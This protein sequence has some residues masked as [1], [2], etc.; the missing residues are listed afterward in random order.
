M[1]AKKGV[2]LIGRS[3]NSASASSHCILPNKKSQI[4][5]SV[6]YNT[7]T[8]RLS[9]VRKILL[10]SLLTSLTESFGVLSTARSSSRLSAAQLLEFEEPQT[11]VKVILVGAMHYN[12]AS[13][14]LAKETIERLGNENRLGSVVV[15][16]CDIR[17]NKTAELYA[18]KPFL[19][20]ILNNEMRTACDAAL[21]FGRPVVLGDQQINVTVTALKASFKQ[22][23][24]DLV[25]PP[26][27]W[28]RFVEEVQE[29]WKETV[30]FGGDG[31]LSA[32]AFFDPRLLL[33][34]PVSLVKYPLSYLVRDPVPTSIGLTLLGALS[35]LDDPTSLESLLADDSISI[36]D[37]LLS[38]GF[39][40]LETAVFARLLL[41]PLLAE[42]NEVLAKRILD[43][44]KI[45]STNKEPK[46]KWSGL[47]WFGLAN[48]EPL[49]DQSTTIYAPGSPIIVSSDKSD[50]VVVAVLGMAHCNGIKRLL[51]ESS[52]ST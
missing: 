26:S 42:R 49:P 3:T 15:E 48:K 43:Q 31:Y 36:T 50:R 34:L 30:P 28:K 39:A 11:G 4:P 51:S 1:T 47:D 32:L 22:T 23:L 12:P 21:A 2:I 52:L 37:W 25:T 45:Y 29:S 8:T 20:K 5:T 35:F 9:W 6:Y 40:A 38:F 13:I 24:Q 41:K 33:V 14:Q 10:F 27:G 18:E 17:W 44:C 46:K 7:M 16:A 19:K